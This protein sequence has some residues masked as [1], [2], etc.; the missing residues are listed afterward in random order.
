VTVERYRGVYL[1]RDESGE[2]IGAASNWRVFMN[3]CG[4]SDARIDVVFD[5]C[6]LT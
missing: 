4:W 6:Q 5:G 2:V 3:E 1:I